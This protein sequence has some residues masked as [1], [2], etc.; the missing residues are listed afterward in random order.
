M[1]G[2]AFLCSPCSVGV[3][4]CPSLVTTLHGSV[5]VLS[6][7]VAFG[8]SGLKS[9]THSGC[10]KE[11]H[12]RQLWWN[13]GLGYGRSL[14]GLSPNLVSKP[15]SSSARV[16]HLVCPENF[17]ISQLPVFDTD[18]ALVCI[19]SRTKTGNVVV[20]ASKIFEDKGYV[21]LQ[22]RGR[23]YS[24]AVKAIATMSIFQGMEDRWFD[25]LLYMDGTILR[26]DKPI[27]NSLMSFAVV[28]KDSPLPPGLIHVEDCFIFHKHYE[29]ASDM[30][31][32]SLKT[33][34][35]DH[36]E[37]EDGVVL[38]C[39]SGNSILACLRGI[40][41]TRGWLLSEGQDML[42]LPYFVGFMDA[43]KDESLVLQ[44]YCQKRT[45]FTSFKG[46]ER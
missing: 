17:E 1:V 18:S 4:A 12:R 42:M 46:V 7:K 34:L 23:G 24:A 5:P 19:H 33:L 43:P 2:S 35:Y 6:M 38:D 30:D 36:F 11:S 32:N 10:G 14:T 44:I 41:Y 3:A 29:V 22:S 27:Q 20:A 40:A 39:T 15:F 31:P 9:S 25:V 45:P 21:V 13:H 26:Y 37:E 16:P 8:F 28:L